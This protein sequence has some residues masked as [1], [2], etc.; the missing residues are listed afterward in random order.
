MNKLQEKESYLVPKVHVVEFKVE[1]G[2][3]LSVPG[4]TSISASGQQNSNSETK[5]ASNF[6]SGYLDWNN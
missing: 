6:G 3:T 5:A 2:Y 1:L 4:T